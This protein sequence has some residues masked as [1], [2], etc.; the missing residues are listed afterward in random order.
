MNEDM[1]WIINKRGRAQDVSNDLLDTMLERGAKV[2]PVEQ[3]VN[4]KPPQSYYPQY[5]NTTGEKHDFT[6]FIKSSELLSV[7]IL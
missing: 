3:L 6:R 4:G 5:D 1:V 7:E 2:F